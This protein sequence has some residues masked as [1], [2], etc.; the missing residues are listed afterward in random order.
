MIEFLYVY[1]HRNNFFNNTHRLTLIFYGRC[2]YPQF[3]TLQ[4]AY[5]YLVKNCL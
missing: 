3:N 4:E 1:L 5:D 2:F